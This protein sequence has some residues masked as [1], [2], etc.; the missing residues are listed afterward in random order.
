MTFEDVGP[1]VRSAMTRLRDRCLD[2]SNRTAST[3]ARLVGACV[4]I[5]SVSVKSK[6]AAV[7]LTVTVLAS[8]V[9][10][11][12]RTAGRALPD[13]GHDACTVSLE[14]PGEIR[15]DAVFGAPMGVKL[16]VSCYIRI[17][18]PWAPTTARCFFCFV[19][20]GTVR[21]AALW[22]SE[23]PNVMNDRS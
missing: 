17:N 12:E 18:E 5:L 13:A 9:P 4:L 2:R 19:I 16:R 22:F 8:C 14:T 20:Q 21:Q 6:I 15:R 23:R 7:R 3:A 10:L 1:R 11:S